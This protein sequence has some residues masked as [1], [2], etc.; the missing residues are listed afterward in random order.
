MVDKG[1]CYANNKYVL[2]YHYSDV[3][4]GACTTHI[5]VKYSGHEAV[6]DFQKMEIIKGSLPRR[7]ANLVLDWVEFSRIVTICGV[8]FVNSSSLE[9]NQTN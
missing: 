8:M 5:H 1:F 4:W 3:L 9:A 7:A 2:R 6:V